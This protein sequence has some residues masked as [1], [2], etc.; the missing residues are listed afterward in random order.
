M[1]KDYGISHRITT[2]VYY[3]DDDGASWRH[4]PVVD[5][6]QSV[7]RGADEPG[8]V[9]LRDGRVMMWLRT[10]LGSIYRCYS[11]D[12]GIT[13]STPA[14]MGLIDPNA[15]QS[16]KRIPSTGDLLLVWNK[17]AHERY[18]L[19]MALSSDDGGAWRQIRNLDAEPGHTYAY[20]SIEFSGDRV[21][22]TYYDA[23]PLPRTKPGEAH[24]LGQN[25]ISLK[26]KSVPA[27]WLYAPP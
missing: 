13:W 20:T 9:E 17:S 11:S 14:S 12:G 19:S 23:L 26:F 16:M 22:F 10:D 4:S 1:T 6:K 8:V 5:I 3:S 7:E 15:P 2:R 27:S 18:P 24:N 21:L 25:S